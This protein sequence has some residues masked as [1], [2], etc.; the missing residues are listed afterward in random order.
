ML[1]AAGGGATPR[2]LAASAVAVSVTG[3]TNETA[4]ATVTIPAGAM[5][6]NGGLRV[7]YN[8]SYTNNA[9]SKTVRLKLGATTLRTLARTTALFDSVSDTVRNRG[10]TNSQFVELLVYAGVGSISISKTTAAEDSLQQL[11]VAITGQLAAGTDTL[12]LESYEVW[13]LP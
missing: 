7:I 2:L 4:L 10:A 13:Q 9:N 12:T 1:R 6:T 5:G 11:T 8:F 3:T